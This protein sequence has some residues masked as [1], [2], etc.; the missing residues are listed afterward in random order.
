MRNQR[1]G[2]KRVVARKGPRWYK[3]RSTQLCVW[4]YLR[5]I[6]DARA[7]EQA[8]QA[9]EDA[10]KKSCPLAFRS[11]SYLLDDVALRALGLENL[12]TLLGRHF[13]HLQLMCRHL[14]DRSSAGG[15]ALLQRAARARS[16]AGRT[17]ESSSRSLV[18]AD[19]F[20]LRIKFMSFWMLARAV[21]SG[22]HT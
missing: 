18:A 4:T 15:A 11:M 10:S 7:C 22:R 14:H 19:G 9:T 16:V 13:S 1:R 17:L 20:L 5:R 12:S 8:W 21:R 6:S 3:H 2:Q